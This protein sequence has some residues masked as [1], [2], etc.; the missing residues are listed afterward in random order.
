MTRHL[1]PVRAEIQQPRIGVL[2]AST[3]AWTGEM[4]DLQAHRRAGFAAGT[5]GGSRIHWDPDGDRFNIVTQAPAAISEK[6]AR[7][8]SRWTRWIPTAAWCT[9]SPTKFYF[10]LTALR[11]RLWRAPA[12]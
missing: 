6:A 2:D 10:L 9:S 12:T 11:T 8:P 5:Q 1:L 4:A 7:P 3:M